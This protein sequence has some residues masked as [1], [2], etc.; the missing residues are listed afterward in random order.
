MDAIEL[1]WKEIETD[2]ELY[3]FYLEIILK[4]AAFVMAFTGAVLSY[5]L[6]KPASTSLRLA[7]WLPIIVNAGMFAVSAV[8]LPFAFGLRRIHVLRCTDAG[9][10]GWY[11]L[12]PLP[13][14][15]IL[16][17]FLYAS[18]TV[19]AIGLVRGWWG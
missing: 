2:L 6:G 4:S 7:L 12:A 10:K 9:L 17:L 5:Y 16:C 18:V 1:A 13:M 15:L 19:G 11:E 8:G 3:R 14:I